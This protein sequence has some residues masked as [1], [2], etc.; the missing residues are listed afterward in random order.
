M[1]RRYVSRAKQAR[2]REHGNTPYA[3]RGRNVVETNPFAGG[4]AGARIRKRRTEDAHLPGNRGPA[5]RRD[6]IR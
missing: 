1:A 6:P 5:P 2:D 3:D 4:S